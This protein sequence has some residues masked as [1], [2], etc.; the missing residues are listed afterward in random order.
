MNAKISNTSFPVVD[1]TNIDLSNSI[2]DNT[3]HNNEEIALL[4]DN[5]SNGNDKNNDNDNKFI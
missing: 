5:Y 4:D 3:M 1:L 2:V